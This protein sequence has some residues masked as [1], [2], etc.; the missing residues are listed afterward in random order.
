MNKGIDD[1]TALAISQNVPLTLI[2]LPA[3]HHAF[4]GV[5][6]NAATRKTIDQTIAFIKGATSPVD[7]SSAPRR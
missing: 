1:L 6:D 4:E 5:D 3:A 2:N 7:Q